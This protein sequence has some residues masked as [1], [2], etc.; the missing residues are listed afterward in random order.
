ME[1][2][3]MHTILTRRPQSGG[4]KAKAA[5]QRRRSRDGDDARTDDRS[6]ESESSDRDG[7]E[8]QTENTPRRREAL[9]ADQERE[10]SAGQ[11]VQA[12]HPDQQDDE[13]E[14]RAAG[15]TTVADVDAPKIAR[16]LPYK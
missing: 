3:Q 6:R 14:A 2:N 10:V 8:D 9:Q 1:G 13:A 4:G 15:T 12:A 11:G 16:M 5:R 7:Q